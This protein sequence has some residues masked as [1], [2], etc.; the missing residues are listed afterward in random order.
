M[1]EEAGIGRNLVIE[2]L[3]DFELMSNTT[4]KVMTLSPFLIAAEK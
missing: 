2:R 1:M 4:K 3:R